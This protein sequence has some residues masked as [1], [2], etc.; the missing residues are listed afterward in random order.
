MFSP[1]RYWVDSFRFS[2]TKASQNFLHLLHTIGQC[3]CVEKT[4]WMP[5]AAEPFP[6][7]DLCA[8]RLFE[9]LK[10]SNDFHQKLLEDLKECHILEWAWTWTLQSA[11]EC[12]FFPKSLE[13]LNLPM[14]ENRV[15]K[16]LS[17]SE[18]LWIARTRGREWNRILYVYFIA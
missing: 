17:L 9:H 12:L 14:P 10:Q 5:C 15:T 11:L 4:T 3:N 6:L 7:H 1:R 13:L 16:T 18:L 8:V 2:G